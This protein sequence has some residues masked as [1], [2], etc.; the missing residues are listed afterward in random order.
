MRD[1][2]YPHR[3]A[4]LVAWTLV[5]L[6]TSSCTPTTGVEGGVSDP[7]GSG[8]AGDVSRV[9]LYSS[10]G[11]IADDSAVVATGRVTAQR[12]VRDIDEDTDFTLSTVRVLSVKKAGEDDIS[13]GDSIVVRQ[14]GSSDQPSGESFLAPGGAYLLYLTASGL[15]G[16]Q[17]DQFYVTG[18]TAGVY[19]LQLEASSSPSVDAQQERAA[20]EPTT[21]FVR[22]DPDSGDSLPSTLSLESALG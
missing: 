14:T 10:V 16:T 7:S 11:E 2:F 22:Q 9:R 3:V 8:S 15:P 5:V 1:K 13:T 4:Q 6:V 17:A 18:A 20:A 12:V 21:E 19:R